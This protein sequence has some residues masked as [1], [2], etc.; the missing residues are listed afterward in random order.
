[1]ETIVLLLDG[2]P[3]IGVHVWSE[4]GNLIGLRHLFKSTAV[5][6]LTL[7]V[8]LKIS[9]LIRSLKKLMYS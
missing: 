9:H 1:M 6:N 7:K 4:I 2:Y 5:A 8:Q 3:E